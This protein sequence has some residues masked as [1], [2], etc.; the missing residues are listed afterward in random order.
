[1]GLKS[2]TTIIM[3]LPFRTMFMGTYLVGAGPRACPVFGQTQGVA[4][5]MGLPDVVHGFEIDDDHYHGIAIPNHVHG[6]ISS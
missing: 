6:N 5:T 4:P 1:M 3:A 2:M